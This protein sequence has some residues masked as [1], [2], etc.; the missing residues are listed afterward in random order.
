MKMRSALLALVVSASVGCRHGGGGLDSG[1]P[2]AG[3]IEGKRIVRLAFFPNVTHAVALVASAN[4]AYSRTLGPGVDLQEQTFNAGPAEIEAL[5]GEQIDIGYIG[6]GPALNGFLKSRGKALRIVAGASSGGVGLVARADSGIVSTKALAGKKVADPQTGGTQDISLRH[7]LQIAGLKSTD[8]GGTVSVLPVA[9]PD[10]LTLF[11]K[12]ELDAAW[13]PEPWVTRLINEG[14]GRILLDERDV[15]P[16]KKFAT[17]VIIV[18]EQFLRE[19]PDDVAK[20]LDAH[21]ETVGWVN[22]HR[23][24][25]RKIVGEQIKKLTSKG[26]PDDVLK[27]ALGR[28][29]FTYDP[30]KQ[31]VLTFAEWARAL[32]YQREDQKVLAS[33]FDLKLLNSELAKRKLKQV[34]WAR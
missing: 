2:A 32:G 25:A 6:P 9:N 7:A 23:E 11:K 1:S 15:W 29:D 34:S 4:G 5:F 14:G 24:Q 26:I 12:K 27:Q 10:M 33:L 30:L 22:G 3:P 13:V 20:I 28:T 31:S 19:H 16:G 21:I 17:T 18:R 8:K